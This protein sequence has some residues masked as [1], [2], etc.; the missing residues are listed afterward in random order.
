MPALIL[1]NPVTIAERRGPSVESKST[2]TVP[3][4]GEREFECGRLIAHQLARGAIIE[5]HATINRYGDGEHQ[6][7]DADP[8][9]M[10][11]A[12][13][14]PNVRTC[15]ALERL[16]WITLRHVESKTVGDFMGISN[17]GFKV[18]REIREAI[19]AALAR[20]PPPRPSWIKKPE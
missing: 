7:P 6:S 12:S 5:A 20:I 16:G 13:L 8:L 17:I 9:D 18:A 15:N 2:H 10:P 14:I 1:D 4:P 3:Q 19:D 11:L